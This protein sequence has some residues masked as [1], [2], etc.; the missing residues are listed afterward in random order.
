MGM[1]GT[2]SVVSSRL[3]DSSGTTAGTEKRPASS[4]V[5]STR[6]LKRAC[7]SRTWT[8]Q[9]FVLFWCHGWDGNR[10]ASSRVLHQALEA[11]LQAQGVVDWGRCA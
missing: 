5:L 4:G 6:P 7:G 1:P 11:R 10:P 9:K 3:A 2:R 8:N